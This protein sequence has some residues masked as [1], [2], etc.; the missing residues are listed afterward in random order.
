MPPAWI[1]EDKELVD[2]MLAGDRRSF[3]DFFEELVPRLYR[4]VQ[5]RVQGDPDTLRELVQATICTT[6]DQLEKYRGEAALFSWICGICRFQILAHYRSKKMTPLQLELADDSLEIRG[7]LE[8]LAGPAL[9]PDDVLRQR[10]IASL[11]HRAL[12]HLPRN[13]SQALEWKYTEEL[14]VVE[15]GERLGISMKAAESVLSRARA[16]FRE[17][18]ATLRRVAGEGEE[19]ARAYTE[20]MTR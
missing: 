12:D 15:I 6:I 14:S 8:S 3:D 2:R 9:L 17:A 5:R 20:G 13:Y 18:F 10:E 11:V 4:F 16:A 19:P 1:H 7:A